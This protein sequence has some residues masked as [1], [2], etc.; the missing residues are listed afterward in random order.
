MSRLVPEHVR[1]EILGLI[2][3]E[4]NDADWDHL[5]QADKTSR[6]SQWVDDPRVGGVLRPLLDSD[7]A[8]RLWLK[9]VALKRRSRQLQPD[10][11]LVVSR[12]FR[13]G[14]RPAADSIGIKPPHCLVES[15][16]GLLYVCWGPQTNAK[17]LFWA[18]LNAPAE[19]P[20]LRE[21]HVIIV[22]RGASRTPPDRRL[23]LE[24][25]A[26]RC[27]VRIAWLPL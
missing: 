3:K 16:S 24:T 27:G 17:N 15:E 5:P 9:D 22:D 14:S 18:A 11:G 19:R 8:V 13:N 21:T 2:A 7:G 6:L 12:V 26:G 10:A 25:L 1:E 4:A 20:D 23:R